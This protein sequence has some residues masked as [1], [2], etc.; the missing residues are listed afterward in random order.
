MKK[1]VISAIISGVLISGMGIQ[2]FAEP[3][4]EE[5][6]K[7]IDEGTENLTKAEKELYDMESKLGEV[8]TEIEV[9]H[10]EINGLSDKAETIQRDIDSADVEISTLKDDIA[11]KEELFGDRL[12]TIYKAGGTNS[13]LQILL[14]SESVSDFFGRVKAINGILSIDKSA[15]EELTSKRDQLNRRIEK[16]E[17]DKKELVVV[18][19]ENKKKIAE[20]EAK[21]AELDKLYDEYK[22]KR[23]SADGDLATREKVMYQYWAD[24]V[25]NSKTS[26]A[27]LQKA[28]GALKDVKDKV[29]SAQAKKEIDDLIS[30][31]NKSI[32]NKELSEKSGVDIGTATG[33]A[34]DV[35]AYGTKYLGYPYVFG[36]TGPN[37]FDCS[38][39]MQHI[40][41]S[42]GI[43]LPRTTYQQVTCGIPVSR[44]NLIPGDL[45]FTEPTASG[46]GHVGVYVG[47]NQM[48]HAANPKQ[49]VII[50]GIYRFSSA[51]RIL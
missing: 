49:G 10:A 39:F 11:V 9:A 40:F 21:K 7:A 8:N 22:K 15:L 25:N 31:A 45:I 48:L 13:Y 51:R 5:Q 36:A 50:G 27:E 46:P 41:R 3:L 38:S 20:Q 2:A 47:N 32:K 14:S 18:E 33:K 23:D 1:R 30:K 16:L 24:L 42:V 43:S 37:A 28:V 29:K 6:Q 44:S 35:I 34:A 12:N 19:E 17:N 4:S 26:K